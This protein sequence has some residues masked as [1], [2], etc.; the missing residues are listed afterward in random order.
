MDKVE[1]FSVRFDKR[2]KQLL[3][4]VL[5]NAIAQASAAI[6]EGDYSDELLSQ[7]EELSQVKNG[8]LYTK[9][10]EVEVEPPVK[11]ETPEEMYKSQDRPQWAGSAP[12]NNSWRD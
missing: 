7:H 6:T 9:P 5:N 10:E 8:L 1:V 4:A 2:T 11:K 3:I 12:L